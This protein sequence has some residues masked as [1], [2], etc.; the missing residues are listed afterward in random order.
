MSKART[1]QHQSKGAFRVPNSILQGL[2]TNTRT[3]LNKLPAFT[4]MTLLGLLALVDSNNPGKEVRTTVSKI[5]AVLEISRHVA[6]AVGRQWTANG[7]VRKEVYQS[8]RYSPTQRKQIDDALLDLHSRRVVIWRSSRNRAKREERIVHLIEMFGYVY[9]QGGRQLDIHDLPPG[10]T[11][12]N[13]ATQERPVYRVRH[14][15]DGDEVE[16]RPTGVMF[17]LSRELAEEFSGMGGTLSFTLFAK[18]VFGLFRQYHHRVPELRLLLLIF[19]QRNVVF[20][21]PVPKLITDLGWDK[22]HPKRAA[23]S[24]RATLEEL[25]RQGI[26]ERHHIDGGCVLEIARNPAWYKL[27]QFGGEAETEAAIQ[28]TEQGAKQEAV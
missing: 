25:K 2:T 12:V 19:R 16:A 10:C 15:K 4:T 6:H 5:L 18:S 13:V 11:K 21:R 1:P 28:T 7:Q 17:R 22:T 14:H 24:L 9:N 8:R 27:P 20:R 23:A 3:E 26:I